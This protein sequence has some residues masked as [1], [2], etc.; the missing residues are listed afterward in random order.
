MRPSYEYFWGCQWLLSIR[1]LFME[2]QGIKCEHLKY[3]YIKLISL[4]G[5]CTK[6]RRCLSFFYLRLLITP[7]WYLQTFFHISLP[8]V[9]TICLS[10]S[11]PCFIVILT[12][13]DRVWYNLI[14]WHISGFFLHAAICLY[15]VSSILMSNIIINT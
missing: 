10:I 2:S 5:K 12:D 13:C 6:M 14:I 4:F 3:S 9:P 1:Y 11:A 8:D 7:F 15:I